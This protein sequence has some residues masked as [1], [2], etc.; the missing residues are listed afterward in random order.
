MDSM[1]RRLDLASAVDH[2]KTAQGRPHFL[3][4]FFRLNPQL[5]EGQGRHRCQDLWDLLTPRHR[6]DPECCFRGVDSPD[7]HSCFTDHPEQWKDGPTGLPVVVAH[8]YCQH[9]IQDHDHNRHQRFFTERGLEYLVSTGSWYSD[10]T[11]LVVIARADVIERIR[12]PEDNACEDHVACPLPTHVDWEMRE[13]LKLAE[14]GVLRNR[15]A[16]LAPEA[17]ANGD[18]LAALRFY[19][20]TAYIDR[21]GG[22]HK[23][24]REQLDH[25]KRIITA[26]PDLD[27]THLYFKNNKDRDYICGPVQP[28]LSRRALDTR[29]RRVDLPPGWGPFR[30]QESGHAIARISADGRLGSAWI[31]QGGNLNLWSASVELDGHRV[32]STSMNEEPRS[33]Y[34]DVNFRCSDPESAVA[35]AIDIWQRYDTLMG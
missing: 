3:E 33:V 1:A 21:T 4:E 13:A 22:F 32:V 17:A 28:Y 5:I 26:Y 30:A 11:R 7:M 19:C 8:P 10:R 9:R 12:L 18:Y 25:A 15:N 24:A 27:K 23:L 20:D 6:E 35:A 29:L 2:S 34:G 14:E 16:Q 31:T